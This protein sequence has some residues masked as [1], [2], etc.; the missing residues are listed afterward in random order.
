MKLNFRTYQKTQTKSIIKKNNF[1]LFA[2]GANQNSS[3]WIA[4]EQN[5]HKLDLAYTKIYNN[6]TTK[7]FQDSVVKKL[8]NTISS[9]FFFL[10]HKNTAKIIK[11]S[12]LNEIST[13]KFDIVALK[14]NKKLYAVP[15]LKKLNS[16][17]YKKNVTVLYQFLST[18]LKSS[19]RF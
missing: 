1:L 13:S 10:I 2:I 11:S 3:N 5:L 19:L 4:L 18:T 14:L 17:H 12:L 9:T 7:I 15:Q 16:F 6:V 8:K